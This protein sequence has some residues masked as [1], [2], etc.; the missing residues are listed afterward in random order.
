MKKNKLIFLRHGQSKW[1]LEN[2]FTGWADVDLTKNGVKEAENAGK[3]LLSYNYN[4]DLVYTSV[5]KRAIKTTE[6]CLNQLKLNN[7]EVSFDWRLN[8]RHYGALQ[9]L[10]KEETAKRYGDDQVHIWRRSY[11]VRP[12]KMDYRD[13]YHPR[14]NELYK[15]IKSNMLP[16]SESLEDTLDRIKPLWFDE[17]IPLLDLGKAIMIVAHG[18]SLRAMV[19]ILAKISDK[20]IINLNIPTGVP[21]IFELD[22]DI[23][24]LDNYFLGNEDYNKKRADFLL[25][26][27][28]V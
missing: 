4:V 5:L 8:E 20:D 28:K 25:R 21:F 9:G 16:S 11:D 10:N 3:L 15:D 14:N 17:I 24:I 19:K 22:D 18:N 26:L 6:I 13:E 7:S 2:R 12:P 1:N 27:A 23:N